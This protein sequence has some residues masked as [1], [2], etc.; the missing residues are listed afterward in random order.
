MAIPEI[1]LRALH[2]L[3]IVGMPL[4]VEPGTA[5]R[6]K[7]SPGV[8]ALILPEQTLARINVDTLIRQLL[9]N[10]ELE[11]NLNRA[12]DAPKAN[13]DVVFK[14]VEFPKPVETLP[15]QIDFT[16]AAS[17]EL[18]YTIPTSVSSGIPFLAMHQKVQG[19][20]GRIQ[21]AL[22]QAGKVT[23]SLAKLQEPLEELEVK[24]LGFDPEITLTWEIQDQNGN[25]ADSK[26]FLLEGT[27]LSVS[28]KK[29]SELLPP[30]FTFL[31]EFGDVTGEEPARYFLSCNVKIAGIDRTVGPVPIEVP[32][33]PVPTI[34]VMT[35][36]ARN[37]VHHQFPGSVLIGIPDFSPLQSFDE[38]NQK[39]DPVKRTIDTVL[40]LLRT[41]YPDLGGLPPFLQQAVDQY[42]FTLD[43]I[44]LLK[45][46]RVSGHRVLVRDQVPFLHRVVRGYTLG[47]AYS[48][49]DEAS[50]LLLVGPPGRAAT[51]HNRREL[52][53]GTGVFQLTTGLGCVVSVENLNSLQF[54]EEPIPTGGGTATWLH[55]PDAESL[56]D[57]ISSYQ[58]LPWR[59]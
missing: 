33:L 11:V 5:V 2:S 38:I 6:P 49:E 19:L 51:F 28:G 1:A 15:G 17:N 44:E 25:A 22:P 55:A 4:R 27:K 53:V 39:L 57:R 13:L 35:E 23:L 18:P 36:H 54:Q 21:G 12:T 42:A 26:L 7:L 50:F 30:V 32:K 43:A 16:K 10:L 34:L 31:P 46:L 24:G 8:D 56:N 29:P 37:A 9:S 58:F 40:S 48:W 20:L 45:Q 41:V 14:A 52:W 3:N 59:V 47:F